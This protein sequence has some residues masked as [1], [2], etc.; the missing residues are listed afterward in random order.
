V[1]LFALIQP[2]VQKPQVGS[3]Q[4]AVDHAVALL[5]EEI[6]SLCSNNTKSEQQPRV[7]KLLGQA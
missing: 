3:R 7:R 2:A 1:L 6:Y 4:R 5:V